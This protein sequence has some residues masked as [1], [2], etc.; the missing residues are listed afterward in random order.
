MAS[1]GRFGFPYQILVIKHC[2]FYD[3]GIVQVRWRLDSECITSDQQW[4]MDIINL[5]GRLPVTP[6]L[7]S[8]YAHEYPMDN[9]LCT[10]HAMTL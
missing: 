7:P 5:K 6:E 2:G 9:L 1:L 8:A 3:S 10:A 4:V